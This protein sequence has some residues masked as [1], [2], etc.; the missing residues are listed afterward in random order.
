MTMQNS[1]DSQQN[2]QNQTQNKTDDISSKLQA[3]NEEIE[4]LRTHSNTILSE[5]KALQQKIKAF[6]D[7]DPEKFSHLVEYYNSSEDAKLISEGKLD[8]VVSKRTERIKAENDAKLSTLQKQLDELVSAKDETLKKYKQ[9]IIDNKI[10]DAAIKAG[11]LPNAIEDVLYRA[12]QIFSLGEDDKLEARNSDG[13]LIKYKAGLLGPNEFLEELKNKAEHYWPQ[14]T[15]AGA[16]GSAEKT[17]AILKD[18]AQS[19]NLS[20]YRKLRKKQSL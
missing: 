15:G 13:T 20:A 2:S 11:V 6:G 14:S 7:I 3:A 19:G 1:T 8:E 10:R 4:R 16:R 9:A 18:A 5:K 17:D 12:R